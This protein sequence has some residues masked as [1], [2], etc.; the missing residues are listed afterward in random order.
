MSIKD[1]LNKLLLEQLAI[2]GDGFAGNRIPAFLEASLPDPA[3]PS[4]TAENADSAWLASLI[5]AP[6]QDTGDEPARSSKWSPA[7]D[8][9][10]PGQT[11]FAHMTAVAETPVENGTGDSAIVVARSGD[12]AIDGLLAGMKWNNNRL[13][14]S[15]PDARADY[16]PVYPEPLDTISRLARPA[17]GAAFRA[18]HHDLQPRRRPSR[19]VFGRGLH[20]SRHHLHRRGFG[21]RDDA[22]CQFR[23]SIDGLCLHS[24]QQRPAR[25]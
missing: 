25:G 22:L 14:Y 9:Q 6:A 7:A 24:R 15:D 13:N 12:Q 17:A 20:R 21:R 5:A 10:R 1:D 3:A 4:S 18:E 11:A 16:Q 8:P 23:R 19:Q 2:I